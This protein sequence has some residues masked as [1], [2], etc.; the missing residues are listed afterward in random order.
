MPPGARAR[1]GTVRLRHTNSVRRVA[2]ALDAKTITS[3]GED[4]WTHRWEAAT[5]KR[6]GSFR[7][8]MA[9]PPAAVS[10]TPVAL[11][12]DGRLLATVVQGTNSSQKIVLWETTSGKVVVELKGNYLVSQLSSG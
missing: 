1:L 3:S 5:G 12:P 6:L 10:E 4:G 11:S 9:E 2:F 8:P 7:S